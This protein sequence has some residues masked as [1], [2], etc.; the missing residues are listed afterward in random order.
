MIV[1]EAMPFTVRVKVLLP[2]VTG[3][4]WPSGVPAVRSGLQG[5]LRDDHAVGR[6]RRFRGAGGVD[7]RDARVR[8]LPADANRLRTSLSVTPLTLPDRTLFSVVLLICNCPL[9]SLVMPRALR[10]LSFGLAPATGEMTRL[11]SWFSML[12]I[13]GSPSST[14]AVLVDGS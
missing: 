7:E 8:G 5:G 12:R 2:P 6:G 1:F 13:D 9:A 3:V 14:P 4:Y 10:L 11:R